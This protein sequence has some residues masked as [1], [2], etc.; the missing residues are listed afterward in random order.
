MNQQFRLQSRAQFPAAARPALFRRD[1]ADL[2]FAN[3]TPRWRSP[4]VRCCRSQRSPFGLVPAGQ[5]IV[6]VAVPRQRRPHRQPYL[7]LRAHHPVDRARGRQASRRRRRGSARARAAATIRDRPRCTALR[8]GVRDGSHVP[9]EGRIGR[10]LFG[11]GRTFSV[12]RPGRGDPR[13]SPVRLGLS[14]HAAGGRVSLLA[15]VGRAA[16]VVAR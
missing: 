16:R 8:A 12:L 7:Q 11:E 2:R 3:R 10:I 13:R 1:A 14:R 4:S 15:A 5:W 6:Q 9:P